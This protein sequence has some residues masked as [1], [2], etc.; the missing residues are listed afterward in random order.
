MEYACPVFHDSL[1]AR[2]SAMI[3]EGVQKRAM[4]ITFAFRS[5]IEYESGLIKLADRRQKLVDKL[6]KEVV[7]SEENKLH[8]LLPALNTC[9]QETHRN[10]GPF[11]RQTDF[12][13]A[14]LSSMPSRLKLCF[15]SSTSF[16]CLLLYL[17]SVFF[18]TNHNFIIVHSFSVF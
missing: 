1:P 7:E 8:G 14:L 9:R 18:L 17:I 12:V 11:S 3:T 4:R 6:F 13:I 10:V 5:Y 2:I 16:D 15:Y